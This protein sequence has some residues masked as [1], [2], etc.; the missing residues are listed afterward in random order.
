M[1]LHVQQTAREAATTQRVAADR[2]RHVSL[3]ARREADRVERE[4]HKS[5]EVR[6]SQNMPGTSKD[7]GVVINGS[8][9]RLP[10]I[11]ASMRRRGKSNT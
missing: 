8:V 4:Y 5:F 11:V 2:E 10:P 6:S 3:H 9:A 1:L 7:T